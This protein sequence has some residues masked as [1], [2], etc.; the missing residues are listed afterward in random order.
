MMR[1]LIAA[2]L[3]LVMLTACQAPRVPGQ[4]AQAANSP[5]E[6]K[7]R[8]II[9]LQ[10]ATNYMEAGQ[11]TV[12]LEEAQQ[13]IAIDPGLAD[14]YHVRA[15]IYA[16]MNERGLAEQSFRSA[17]SLRENDG[18]LLNNYGW[19]LCQNGRYQDAVPMLE[20]AAAAPSAS[21]PLKPQ[22]SLGV[23]Q[24]RR[25]ELASAEKSLQKA[26]AYD[27]NNAAALTNLAQV[28]YQRGD[29]QRAW[30]TVGRV[31]GGSAASAQS[32]WLGARIA[33][34]QGDTATQEAMVAQLRSR[35]P[36]SPE[37]AAYEQ[38]AWNE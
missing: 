6:L 33:H 37:L 38:G 1:L 36:E 9:R 11:N 31:N 12:A 15:L 28:Y 19:F 29:F 25:G 2:L 16:N 8:A 3:G 14:A 18:D 10:L 17:V 32:L 23:C 22:I 20:R 5:A 7:R 26:L 21:G 24:L 30:Q 4:D 13:A 34:R 35:F 27:R